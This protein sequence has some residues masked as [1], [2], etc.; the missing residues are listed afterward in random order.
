MSDSETDESVQRAVILDYLPHGRSDDDRPQYRRSAVGYALDTEDFHVYEFALADDA[1]L[2]IGDE[3]VVEPLAEA[4]AVE[5]VRTVDL[6]ELPSGAASELEYVIDDL[7]EE[8]TDRFVRVYNE[9]GPITLRLH[10]LDLLPGIGDK[11]RDAI[12]DERKR[13]P[14]EDFEDVA[15]RIDGLHDPADV[16]RER[17]FEELRGEDLKYRLFALRDGSE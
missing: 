10:Q 8:E 12:L 13:E 2:S 14:F 7:L 5:H 16:I 6:E 9:A 4:D 11:L 17:I 3:I 15:D 1:D